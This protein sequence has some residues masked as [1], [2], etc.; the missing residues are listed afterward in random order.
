MFLGACGICLSLA[1]STTAIKSPL[2]FHEL[3]SLL[4]WPTFYLFSR[5]QRVSAVSGEALIHFSIP[6]LWLAAYPLIPDKMVTGIFDAL[7]LIQLSVYLWLSCTEFYRTSLLSKSKAIYGDYYLKALMTG[8]AFLLVLRLMLPMTNLQNH[9]IMVIFQATAGLYFI[10]VSFFH[11][12]TPLKSQ[13]MGKE[14]EQIQESVNYEEEV[15][16]KLKIAMQTDKA[17]LNPELTLHDLAE[18]TGLK[19]AELSNFIN[20]NMGRNFNDFINEYRIREF[21][22]LVSTEADPKATLMELAYQSGFNSKASFNRLFKEYTGITPSQFKKSSVK[23][24][25]SS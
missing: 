13:A 1:I 2:I 20:K 22:R 12:K 9:Q 21:K 10:L 23:G 17:Y 5:T 4:I 7:Y 14:V 24:A 16:R 18:T 19:L 6:L 3:L 25:A 8:T 11:L 15:K